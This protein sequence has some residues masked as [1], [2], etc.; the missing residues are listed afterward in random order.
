MTTLTTTEL[1]ELAK[2]R[3][4]ML[5]Y[6]DV[7]VDGERIQSTRVLSPVFNIDIKREINDPEIGPKVRRGKYKVV[8]DG[9]WLYLDSYSLNSFFHFIISI[10]KI[11]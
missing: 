7:I 9:Y 5:V 3:I 10:I 6:K 2:Q 4:D 8:S 11:H 1:I